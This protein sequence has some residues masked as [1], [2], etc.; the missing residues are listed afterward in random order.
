MSILLFAEFACSMDGKN[1]DLSKVVISFHIS[2]VFPI[3]IHSTNVNSLEFLSQPERSGQ[4]AS[5]P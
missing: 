2:L 5:S 4:G 1:Y 3:L